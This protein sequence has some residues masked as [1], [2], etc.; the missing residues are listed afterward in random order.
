MNGIAKQDI[1]RNNTKQAN[2]MKPNVP[3]ANTITQFKKG[4]KGIVSKI[5]P[6][7]INTSFVTLGKTRRET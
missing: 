7:A 2:K 6:A 1:V 5:V 3:L 4:Y